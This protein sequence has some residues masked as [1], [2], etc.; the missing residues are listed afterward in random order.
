MPYGGCEQGYLWSYL[1]VVD[2]DS[3]ALGMAT[4]DP[5]KLKMWSCSLLTTD[6]YSEIQSLLPFVLL[7][8]VHAHQ[9]ITSG[10][11]LA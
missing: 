3:C 4:T 7:I 11:G 10:E 9:A 1:R 6:G 2:K 8:I 5:D